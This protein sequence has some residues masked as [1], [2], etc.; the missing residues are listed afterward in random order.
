MRCNS[1]VASACGTERSSPVTGSSVW[2][3]LGV[4][5]TSR[6]EHGYLTFGVHGGEVNLWFWRAYVVCDGDAK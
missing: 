3:G 2:C 5:V 1:R 6:V 4:E